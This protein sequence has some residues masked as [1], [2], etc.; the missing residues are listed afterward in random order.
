MEVYCVHIMPILMLACSYEYS[1]W[2]LCHCLGFCCWASMYSPSV[3]ACPG[4]CPPTHRPMPSSSAHSS[5]YAPCSVSPIENVPLFLYFHHMNLG[6]NYKLHHKDKNNTAIE[7]RNL[8]TYTFV[9]FLLP[10]IIRQITGN[11]QNQWRD[12][13]LQVITLSCCCYGSSFW[14]M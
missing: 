1:V 8:N 5:S 3:S 14:Q 10:S 4:K 11:G 9:S 13:L 6:A 7:S 2:F 12:S